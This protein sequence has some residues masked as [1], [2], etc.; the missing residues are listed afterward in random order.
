MADDD[1][2]DDDDRRSPSSAPSGPA[3]PPPG[4]PPPPPRRLG[5]WEV[6]KQL[7]RGSFAVVWRARHV[8]TRRRVALKEIDVAKLNAKLRES[9][10]SEIA[11]LRRVRHENIIRLHDIVRANDPAEGGRAP[12]SSSPS[13]SSSSSSSSSAPMILVL[14]YCAGGDVAE[15][16]RRV[17]RCRE[18]VARRL[19]R[20]VAAGLR[21]MRERNLVHR[22][23]KPQNL[24]L[25]GDPDPPRRPGPGPDA[26]KPSSREA[27]AS[28]SAVTLKIAD[29]GFA[30]YV[31]PAGMAETLCGSPLYMAPEILSYRKYDAKADLWSVG[32]I[33]YELLV[34]RPPFSGQ[35]PMQLRRVIERSGG[36]KIP[37][38][39]AR[40]LSPECVALL[41]GLLR[42]DPVERMSFEEFF[43]HPFFDEPEE[44]E[45][46][47]AAAGAG[48]GVY[49]S[50]EER[51]AGG[52]G[53]RIRDDAMPREGKDD[54]RRE[55]RDAAGRLV[56]TRSNAEGGEASGGASS[57]G[58]GAGAGGGGERSSATANAPPRLRSVA[59]GA[60]GPALV[61]A[62]A[63]RMRDAAKIA[64][65][66]GGAWLGSS[67]LA[68]KTASLLGTSPGRGGGGEARGG[69]RREALPGTD[70][71][72]GAD[73]EGTNS[74]Y[75]LVDA[76]VGPERDDETPAKCGDET[77]AKRGDETPAESDAN[78]RAVAAATPSP[79]PPSSA[80]A[81]PLSPATR[82]WVLRRAAAI[83]RDAA[84]EFWDRGRRADAV[85]A[86]LTSLSALRR[87][88]AVAHARAAEAA[89][90]RRAADAAGDAPGAEA[91]TR[92]VE[93]AEE[94]AA[95]SRAGFEAA[96]R[97]AERAAEA[98]REDEKKRK[99]RT[100]LP[101]GA[102]LAYEAA[103]R[104]GRAGAAEEL[105]GNA[106]AAADAYAAA[107]TLLAF[108]RSEGAAF[109]R[110]AGEEDR[111]DERRAGERGG[112]GG[113]AGDA[114]LAKLFAA[115]AARRDAC[116][117]AKE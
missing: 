11:V 22:D 4:P 107:E 74:G 77:P 33:L 48:R 86:S 113:G 40:T 66:A 27:D 69:R 43:A 76:G 21:A 115:V 101:D 35:T 13:S 54:E 7:G 59:K 5:P 114:A 104:L 19:V 16:L 23:L 78:A 106:A 81:P 38:A 15:Y 100:L 36:A 98:L 50:R 89:A 55:S 105:V 67:P 96:R 80:L 39:V 47:E 95:R 20:Q 111:L 44:E 92:D 14:E 64:A 3:P 102:A 94:D 97:R 79:F 18:A 9:L 75:V 8:Q 103:L 51:A 34:G 112:E 83:M 29:F 84:A 117:R 56:E 99:S 25:V 62:C 37:G 41:G 85:A 90:R 87:A 116:R 45:A 73:A 42:K 31:H 68:R 53:V 24:L 32:A 93:A 109:G 6:E 26:A 46:G 1:D 10:E 70:L 28:A 108:V 17:G 60:G 82:S 72:E 49:A 58:G 30:R 65:A 57:G 52:A 2:V 61:S 91:A 71:L 88:V 12:Y 63:A 110:R